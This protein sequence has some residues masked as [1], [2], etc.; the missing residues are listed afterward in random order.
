MR[1][2]DG[3]TVDVPVHDVECDCSQDGDEAGGAHAGD[4]QSVDDGAVEVV[5]DPG[6]DEDPLDE[7][8]CRR[9]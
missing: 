8:R 7:C 5:S 4:P 1:A 6:A 2:P 9:L 3:C